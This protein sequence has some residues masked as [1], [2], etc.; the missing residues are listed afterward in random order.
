MR[1]DLN[2]Y[3]S[4]ILESEHNKESREKDLMGKENR[5]KIKQLSPE[6]SG[7]K[8]KYDDR[9]RPLQ[10][11]MSQEEAKKEEK[12]QQIGYSQTHIPHLEDKGSRILH[13]GQPD[14]DKQT[15]DST[16]KDQEVHREVNGNSKQHI[17]EEKPQLNYD[18]HSQDESTAALE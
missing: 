14:F 12:S 13:K 18:T 7:E 3:A 17:K 10:Q 15:P 9:A 1:K 11:Q 4:S 8:E 5:E 6:G 2:S 16:P